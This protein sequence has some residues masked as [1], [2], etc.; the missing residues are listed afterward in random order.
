ML[1]SSVLAALEATVPV[2]QRVAPQSG[3]AASTADS[4]TT[5]ASLES[6]NSSGKGTRT[7]TTSTVSTA[8]VDSGSFVGVPRDFSGHADGTKVAYMS[9]EKW[10]VAALRKLGKEKTEIVL[11]SLEPN[12]ALV[13]EIA[14]EIPS[15]AIP[16]IPRIDT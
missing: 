4:E 15:F 14:P 3:D 1:C 12:D 8:S 11:P 9:V 6:N 2:E 7:S 5:E 13:R 10:I 16:T